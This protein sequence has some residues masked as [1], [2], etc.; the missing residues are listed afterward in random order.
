MPG[1]HPSELKTRGQVRTK[2]QIHMTADI[3][4]TVFNI[5]R[6]SIN[7]G[8][9]IRTT[10]F[11]KGCPLR[12]RWCHNPESISEE[13]EIVLRMDRCIRC[14]ACVEKCTSNAVKWM[15]DSVV[16]EREHCTRC[17]WC[18]EV[19]HTEA[20]SFSGKRVTA[21]FILEEVL[22]DVVFYDQSGG[23][24]TFSG[25]EPF[26][27]HEFLISLLEQCKDRNIH[28]AIDTSGYTSP[29]NLRNAC[30]Y[31]DLFMYDIKTLDRIKH[32]RFTG[33]TPDLIQQNLRKLS[34]WGMNII[35]RIPL[36]PGLNDDIG[37]MREIGKFT[38]SMRI[39]KEIHILPY[40]KA[41]ISKYERLGLNYGMDNIPVPGSD[42]VEAFAEELRN[43]VRHVHV[44]KS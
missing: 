25:G 28:T 32:A 19:C 20:R 39:I 1:A 13:N 30:D 41:G 4:G 16:T 11:L 35:V 37:S 38:A 9:G 7:D 34:E 10:V 14:G 3:L 31:T 43:Y 5:Q 2:N 18:I 12:C 8:P 40:H 23:G 26:L 6:F 29:E 21:E 24:A 27:Q 44:E 33:V 15:G 42:E 36:I 17:G 22:K